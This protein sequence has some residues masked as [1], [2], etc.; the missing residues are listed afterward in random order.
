MIQR[1]DTCQLQYCAVSKY[2]C[3]LYNALLIQN[4]DISMLSD[5]SSIFTSPAE[6]AASTTAA[7]TAASTP[8]TEAATDSS[9][10]ANLITESTSEAYMTRD[11]EAD[12][13]SMGEMT[14]DNSPE[15]LAST[16]ISGR[17][18]LRLPIWSL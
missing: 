5:F 10:S 17:R 12:N 6:A 14:Y 3:D 18:Q 11:S 7:E 8:A 1:I 2:S 4:E 9:R 16:T 15:C 13:D